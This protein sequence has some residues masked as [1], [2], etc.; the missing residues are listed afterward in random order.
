MADTS[1][2]SIEEVTAVN[3]SPQGGGDLIAAPPAWT[4]LQRAVAAVTELRAPHAHNQI[5]ALFPSL[6][7]FSPPLLVMC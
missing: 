7:S 3:D 1:A 5:G 6:S 2:A 4:E